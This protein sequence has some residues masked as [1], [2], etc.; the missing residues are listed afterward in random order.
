MCLHRESESKQRRGRR[1]RT[2]HGPRPRRTPASPRRTLQLAEGVEPIG[3]GVRRWRPAEL[4]HHAREAGG[5][6][7]QPRK[8]SERSIV[9]QDGIARLHVQPWSA[10]TRTRPA[11]SAHATCRQNASSARQHN[12]LSAVDDA[13]CLTALARRSFERRVDVVARLAHK[14]DAAIGAQDD[15]PA[16]QGKLQ[17]LSGVVEGEFEHKRR[18]WKGRK[19]L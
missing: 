7:V 10:P 12:A 13:E 15:L 17:M 18:T 16:E 2:A 19:R 14:L 6:V 3:Q 8:R 1:D 5:I 9:R 4:L 11:A